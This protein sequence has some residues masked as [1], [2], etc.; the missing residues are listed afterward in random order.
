MMGKRQL[1]QGDLSDWED[2][3]QSAFDYAWR[4]YRWD[5][6]LRR[7]TVDL[8]N[9]PYL[10]E[11]F[12]IGGYRKALGDTTGDITELKLEDYT[13]LSSGQR[14]FT[15]E[16]DSALNRYKV[17]TNSGLTTMDF[18]YQ[19]T[20]P[21]LSDKDDTTQQV[22]P[23]PFPSAMTIAIGASVYS[24]QGENPT[25]ADISQEWDE[26][27][28]ELDRHVGRMENNKSAPT[29]LN[30]QDQFGTYTGYVG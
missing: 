24:K 7:A 10:P 23:V 15:L 18:L 28:A 22:I 2:Y 9:D 8:A 26:W 19:V 12:D 17:T 4:Y 11:D 30:L 14:V 29:N 1:P 16:Y 3:A 21:T 27:H 6:S 13:R 20:P 5:W 25:R